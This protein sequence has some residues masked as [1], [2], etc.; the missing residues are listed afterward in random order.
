M[1]AHL[2]HERSP[3]ARAYAQLALALEPL[4]IEVGPEVVDVWR[5]RVRNGVDPLPPRALRELA[6]LAERLARRLPR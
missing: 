2:P 4:G 1:S 6:A 3:L 5:D